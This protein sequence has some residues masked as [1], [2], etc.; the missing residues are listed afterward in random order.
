MAHETA[1]IARCNAVVKFSRLS[2]S[3]LFNWEKLIYLLLGRNRHRQVYV[4]IKDTMYG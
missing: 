1:I 2:E 3:S 4:D